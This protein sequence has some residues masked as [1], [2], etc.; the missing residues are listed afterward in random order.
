MIRALT[1]PDLGVPA[2]PEC[3]IVEWANEDERIVFSYAR[4]GNGITFHLAA[5]KWA[6]RHLEFAI[7][8][9]CAWLFWAYEWCEMVFGM[10]ARSSIE[11]VLKRCGFNWLTKI[12]DLEIYVRSK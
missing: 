12:A 8:E 3:V 10:T 1:G 9:F 5:R 2:I 6:L 11:K 7:N 4:Q